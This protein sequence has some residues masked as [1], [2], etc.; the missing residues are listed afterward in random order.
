MKSFSICLLLFSTMLV[1]LSPN[2]SQS[3]PV[4]YT[5]EGIIPNYTYISDKAGIISEAGLA[6][7]SH[8]SYTVLLDLERPGSY[9]LNNGT[10]YTYP[11][12]IDLDLPIHYYY[13]EYIGGTALQEK[14]GGSHNLPTDVAEYNWLISRPF[15]DDEGRFML[16]SSDNPLI[17]I[18]FIPPQNWYLGEKFDLAIDSA[19]D[20]QGNYSYIDGHA[21]NILTLTNI[22]PVTE[23]TT[24]LL[25]ISGLI[26]LVVTRHRK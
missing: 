4:V 6:A 15:A 19:Y 17:I 25:T 16:G 14:D 3:A 22:T 1:A 20:S 11:I 24:W 9:I 26:V 8:I 7:G 18:G 13:A 10:T 5:F 23:P 2:I 12:T 21:N